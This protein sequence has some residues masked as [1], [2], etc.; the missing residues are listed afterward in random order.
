M[1]VTV[2]HVVYTHLHF[3]FELIFLHHWE[4]LIIPSC[5]RMQQHTAQWRATRI[6]YLNCLL[7]RRIRNASPADTHG[8]GGA[9]RTRGSEV[10]FAGQE[11]EEHAADILPQH[12]R[13]DGVVAEHEL[14]QASVR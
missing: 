5:A 12:R 1:V 10:G 13:H 8:L 3:L 11:A 6:Y 7:A 2:K 14:P 9:G 4:V